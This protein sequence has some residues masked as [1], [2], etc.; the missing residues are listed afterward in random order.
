[1]SKILVLTGA[2]GKKSGGILTENIG[3]NIDYVN[4]AFPDGISAVVR[5]TSNVK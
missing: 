3:K 1:M 5:A 2:T 4:A